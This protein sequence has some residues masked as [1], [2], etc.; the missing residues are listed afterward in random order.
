MPTHN[1]NITEHQSA[2][3]QELV[4]AGSYNSASEVVREGL[5]LVEQQHQA[6]AEKLEALRKIAKDAFDSL[7]RGESV[8]VPFEELDAFLDARLENLEKKSA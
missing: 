4:T 6:H 1:V 2:F 3:I 8:R 5:R 7:D